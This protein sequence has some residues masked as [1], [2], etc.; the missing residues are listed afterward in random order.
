MTKLSYNKNIEVLKLMRIK[1]IV[2]KFNITTTDHNMHEFEQDIQDRLRL[3]QNLPYMKIILNRA[4]SLLQINGNKLE[5][6]ENKINSNVEMILNNAIPDF[7]QIKDQELDNY[8]IT[9]KLV[10]IYNMV[11]EGYYKPS[12]DKLLYF[13][14][15]NTNKTKKLDIY[16]KLNLCYKYFKDNGL[17]DAEIS[18]FFLHSDRKIRNKLAHLDYEIDQTGV[19]NLTFVR[20]TSVEIFDKILVLLNVGTLISYSIEQALNLKLLDDLFRGLPAVVSQ[21]AELKQLLEEL[22]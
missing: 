4:K 15:Y 7:N 2:D 17:D 6:F 5:E 18:H 16:K 11:F 22:I 14:G 19:L 3:P 20:L 1:D 12:I 8:Q 10:N 9:S 21:D 13:L